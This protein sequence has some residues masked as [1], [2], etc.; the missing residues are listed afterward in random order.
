MCVEDTAS[1]A[2]NGV[3]LSGLSPTTCGQLRQEVRALMTEVPLVNLLPTELLALVDILGTA[4]LRTVSGPEELL[5][6][7]LC[8]SLE[9]GEAS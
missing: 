3:H 1:A 8:A 9:F 4:L 7:T 6:P 5:G 2:G